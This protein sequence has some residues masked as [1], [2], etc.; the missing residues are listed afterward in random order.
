MIPSIKVRAVEGGCYTENS[1]TLIIRQKEGGKKPTQK[2]LRVETTKKNLRILYIYIGIGK[3]LTQNPSL[4]FKIIQLVL[5]S[6]IF[7]YRQ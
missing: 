4:L 1:N 6:K 7:V 2:N 5:L 3:K